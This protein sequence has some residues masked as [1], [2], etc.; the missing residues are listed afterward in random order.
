LNP[1]AAAA[2]L[3]ISRVEW[4]P[5]SSLVRTTLQAGALPKGTRVPYLSIY[6]GPDGLLPAT[7]TDTVRCD[8]GGPLAAVRLDTRTGVSA[9]TALAPCVLGA[10]QAY[11]LNHGWAVRIKLRGCR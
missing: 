6:W 3:A 4:K 5:D 8:G 11:K 10:D 9:V 1:A 7:V 2:P